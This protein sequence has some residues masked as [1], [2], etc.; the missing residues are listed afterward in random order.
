MIASTGHVLAIAALVAA[1]WLFMGLAV[2]VA[3]GE[4]AKRGDRL[5]DETKGRTHG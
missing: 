5:Y 1:W 3:F 2:A 4:C